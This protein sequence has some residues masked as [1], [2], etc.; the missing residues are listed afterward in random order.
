[1]NQTLHKPNRFFFGTRSLPCPY[2]DGQME[3]KVVTDLS[4]ENSDDLYAR[5]SRAGFRRSHG[6][7]YRPACPTCQS[8]VPVRI[9][10]D[11]FQW[12]KSFRRT[13][14]AN[15]D[16]FATDLGTVATGEQYRLFYRYQ[17]SRHGGGEMAAMSFNDYRA[18]VEDTPV[19]T[20]IVEFRDPAGALV[21]AM[22]CDRMEDSFSAVYS[23]FE[24]ELVSRSLGTFMVLWLVERAVELGLSHVYLGYWIDGSNKMSYKAR[25]QPLEQLLDNSWRTLS[26]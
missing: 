5:L 26:E 1:M 17:H 11:G 2:I 6:L 18:M 16:L 21:G 15:K 24:P 20:R 23:F 14:R 9:D 13:R 3:R 8:C 19:E 25:F 22:L 4:G 12:S 7:A 10:A